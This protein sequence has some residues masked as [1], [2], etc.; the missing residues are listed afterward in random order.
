MRRLVRRVLTAAGIILLVVVLALAPF[1]LLTPRAPKP[2]VIDSTDKLDAY[3]ASLTA[4]ETPPAIEV[5][6]VRNGRTIYDKAFGRRDAAGSAA[7]PGDI[8]HF[9]SVTKLFTATAILQLAEDG[10]IALDD[11]VAKYLPGFVTT[12]GGAPAPIT[13]RQLLAH[14]AGMKDLSPRDLFGWIHHLT[15]PAV[16]QTAIVSERMGAYRALATAPNGA[17]AYSN[18]GYIVLGAIVEAVSGGSYEDFVR[19]RILTPLGMTASDYVYRDDMLPRAVAG[20][21]PLFH[22]FT[23]MLPA[24]HR[25]WFSQWV[26]RVKRQRMWLA[27]L[28]TDYTGPTGLI[29]TAADLARFGEA[30]LAGGGLDGVRI[31]KPETV[32]AML[33]DGYGGNAGPDK[34]RMGLGWH[35]WHDAPIPFKGHGGEGPGFGA[36]LALFPDRQMVVVV[37]ANDTL[38]DR[39]GLANLVAG[40]FAIPAR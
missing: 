28:Y 20:S 33:N 25:D 31:L 3:L 6:V 38:I 27:P 35:W 14:T 21:H 9:W 5:A 1:A 26:K 29:G 37:L 32:A 17:G 4:N 7:Q 10:K 24:L 22:F 23:P 8:Y 39:V 18:A 11:A 34:D 2:G 30:Y 40:V 16:S 36:Q 13:V 12:F 19:R 15:D